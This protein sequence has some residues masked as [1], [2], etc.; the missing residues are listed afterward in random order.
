LIRPSGT[1]RKSTSRPSDRFHQEVL[2]DKVSVDQ[3]VSR[4]WS[5]RARPSAVI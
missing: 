5:Y 4:L 3:P 1:Q 2:S